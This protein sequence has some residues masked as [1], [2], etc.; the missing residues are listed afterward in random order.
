MD[1]PE[2]PIPR[3]PLLVAALTAVVAPARALA[4]GVPD[5]TIA[6][7]SGFAVQFRHPIEEL[8][9][10]LLGTER[11]DPRMQASVPHR[12][13]Y[14]EHVLRKFGAWGPSPRAYPP[15]AIAEGKSTEWRRERVLAEALRFLG[16]GYQHHHV[17]DWD[18]PAEWPWKSTC[19][20][21]NGKGFDC[22]NFTSFVY[23]QG[24]GV[25]MSSAVERQAETR[26]AELGPEGRPIPLGRVELAESYAER[27]QTLRTGDLVYIRGKPGGPITHVILWVGP[28]GRSASGAP[29]IL[30][31]HGSG[32]DD[33]EGRPIPCGVQLRPFREKSWY[34]RCASH[35]HRV[36]EEREE[37]LGL[38]R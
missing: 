17:P 20:G 19:V 14:S 37:H 29:L 22:S 36:F 8:I 4:Q 35:A 25:R 32:V 34:N 18:P 21:S 3:R 15:A 6:A 27:I 2:P 33:D 12:E 24:F 28:I 7:P 10:D 30:D 31:S 1:S 13:W 16:Y 23:N 9:G 11:G 5:R 38:R 26:H